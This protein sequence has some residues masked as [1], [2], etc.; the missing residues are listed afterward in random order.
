MDLILADIRDAIQRGTLYLQNLRLE[1]NMLSLS[2]LS[3]SSI[4]PKSLRRLLVQI[5]AKMP[6]TLKLPEDPRSNIWYYYLT[7]TCTTVLDDHKVIV[8]IN[9]PLLDFTGEYEVYRVHNIPLPMHKVP[10]EVIMTFATDTVARYDIEYPGLL[11]NKD[12]TLYTPLNEYEMFTCSNRVARYCSP[13]NAVLPV[14]INRLCILAL[15]LKHDRNV[16][17]NCQKIV[18][19]N[20]LLPMGTYL[21]QGLWVIGTKEKLDFAIVCHGT[22]GGQ[23]SKT[24]RLETVMPPLSIIHLDAGCH[25]SNNFLSLP[26]YYGFEEHAEIS[27]L[28]DDLIKIHNT[29]NFRIWEPF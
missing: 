25:A 22:S 7:L 4:T 13:E 15:F 11:I 18:L 6:S 2:R 10:K 21:D 9:I 14:N 26:P 1:L 5:S 3:P 29:T 8:V 24:Q 17:Q 12:R 27:D 20:A 23:S 16:E 28:Y 19:P